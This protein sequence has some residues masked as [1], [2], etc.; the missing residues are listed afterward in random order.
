MQQIRSWMFLFLFVSMS[1]F[2]GDLPKGNLIIIG[3]GSIPLSV[4]ETFVNL[5]GGDDARIAVIP[6]AS[7]EYRKAGRKYVRGFKKLGV[8]EAEA[9]YVFGP[10]DANKTEL[11]TGLDRYT[12]FFFGGGDQRELTRIFLNTKALDVLQRKYREGAVV[13]GTSAGAAIM[14]NVMITGDGNWD[15]LVKGSV[16]TQPG[17][18]FVD[19]FITDQHFVARSRLNRL[20]SVCLE[21]N[22]PGIGIDE[23]TALW[24]KPIGGATVIGDS[25]VVVVEPKGA[26][27]GTDEGQMWS[28]RD[29]GLSV[30]R[31]GDNIDLTRFRRDQ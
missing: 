12:G 20:I 16:V 26:G 23:G 22:L 30:L 3:G 9:F 1:G 2:A 4:M 19:T 8:A 10:D 11:V 15:V 18:G 31:P 5:A 7:S 28:A 14:S 25:V 24:V 21:H 29:M 13:A 6:M 27:S 17:L